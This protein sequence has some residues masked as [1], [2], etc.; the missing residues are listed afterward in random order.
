VIL[1]AV[2]TACGTLICAVP[3]ITYSAGKHKTKYIHPDKK[4]DVS[5]EQDH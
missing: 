5:G 2:T 1:K 4:I 3:L